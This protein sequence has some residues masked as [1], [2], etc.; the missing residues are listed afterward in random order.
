MNTH[1]TGPIFSEAKNVTELMYQ[2][3]GAASMCWDNGTGVFDD[4]S[5]KKIADEGID[6]LIELGWAEI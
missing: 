6:R 5:A 4:E 1:P 3:V 2:I